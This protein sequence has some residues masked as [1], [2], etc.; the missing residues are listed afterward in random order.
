M[1]ELVPSQLGSQGRGAGREAAT[2]PGD[3]V[4]PLVSWA[5]DL[6]WV[7]AGELGMV[8]HTRH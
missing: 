5:M 7:E 2:G 3:R 1:P 8:S 6:S 4:E